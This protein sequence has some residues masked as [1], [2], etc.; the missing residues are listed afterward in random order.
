MK[1]TYMLMV[2]L[3]TGSGAFCQQN[4]TKASKAKPMIKTEKI[5]YY[6][7]KPLKNERSYGF[8]RDLYKEY[9][10]NGNQLTESIILAKEGT[11]EDENNLS[12]RYHYQT[13][14]LDKAEH[15]S[16]LRAGIKHEEVRFTYSTDGK[17]EKE[18]LIVFQD[19]KEVLNKNSFYT[20][21]SYEKDQ[22]EEH[23][24]FD[25]AAQKFKLSYR[26]V[27]EFDNRRNLIKETNYDEDHQPYRTNIKTYNDKNQI[28]REIAVDQYSDRDES[29]LYNP[30]GDVLKINAKNRGEVSYTY[31]YDEHNNWIEKTEKEISVNQGKSKI[32]NHHLIKR[33]IIYY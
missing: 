31:K 6:D 25:E 21:Y 11:D 12:Y 26:T 9:D 28:I 16:V 24:R 13:G 14:K 7:V 2:L 10:N 5:I 22:K 4:E 27:K 3:S 19:G 23:W 17:L 33:T 8:G 1:S 20:L 32:S 15:F 18:A 29:I 30:Q